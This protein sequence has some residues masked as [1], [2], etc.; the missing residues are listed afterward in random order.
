MDDVAAAVRWTVAH[1]ADYG[2][3]KD[4]IVLAGQ[5]A[6]AHICMC[7][8][9]AALQARVRAL[10]GAPTGPP[11]VAAAAEVT[12][13]AA[14]RYG[15][16]VATRVVSSSLA[17]RSPHLSVKGAAAGAGG[18]GPVPIARAA[19]ADWGNW[20]DAEPDFADA[21]DDNATWRMS[22]GGG[23]AKTALSGSGN[24]SGNGSGQRVS[25]P[26][27]AVADAAPRRRIDLLSI[28]LFIGISGPYNLQAMAAHLHG[29]GLDT[30]I[31][32]WVCKGDLAKYSPAVTLARH[33]AAMAA[34]ADA[35]AASSTS[36]ESGSGVS[37]ATSLGTPSHAAAAG[38]DA[39]DVGADDC[40][41]TLQDPPPASPVSLG[42][43][44]ADPSSLTAS[45]LT[46]SELRRRANAH[47]LDPLLSV[48]AD[49]G[50]GSGSGPASATASSRTT[51]AASP[52]HDRGPSPTAQLR[53]L[54]ALGFPPVALF[55]GSQDMTVPSAVSAEMAAVLCRGGG[56][57]RHEAAPSPSISLLTHANHRHPTPHAPPRPRRAGFAAD[58]RGVG[59]HGRDPGGAGA[60]RLHALQRHGQAGV[61]CSC[62]H[63]LRSICYGWARLDIHL[64]IPTHFESSDSFRP[65]S[66]PLS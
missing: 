50:S 44:P 24:G 11:T 60:R 35:D 1:A 59:A 5:S 51:P 19:S 43:D 33:V 54:A 17:S 58:V 28:K 42:P 30:S 57:V 27:A 46:R 23:S 20:S 12:A 56:E 32:S 7:A 34:E 36:E 49:T 38:A 4:K 53:S 15:P 6:G 18:R 62:M 39:G 55:H 66:D 9:V 40:V 63:I 45:P 2:G 61:P 41:D 13:Q 29:R 37:V 52:S 14:A 10:A 26:A 8:L 21:E 25:A 48:S 64:A 65:L 47:L 22:D 31:L 16:V 3:D